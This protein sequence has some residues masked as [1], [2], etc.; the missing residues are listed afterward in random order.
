MAHKW[1][2]FRRQISELFNKVFLEWW[3]LEPALERGQIPL[4]RS[5]NLGVTPDSLFFYTPIWIL[6]ALPLDI[7][8]LLP[9][10]TT[11]S[12]PNPSPPTQIIAIVSYLVS[13]LLHLPPLQTIFHTVVRK[14]QLKLKSDKSLLWLLLSFL[15]V[16]YK[17]QMIWPS[18]FI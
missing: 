14:V 16:P 17:A 18:A 6:P 2:L 10:S 1:Y 13:L 9:T 7:E 12:W 3:Q 15:I 5:I 4:C 11:T 8:S